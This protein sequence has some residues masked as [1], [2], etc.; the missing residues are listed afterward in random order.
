MINSGSYKLIGQFFRAVIGS[1]TRMAYDD[2]DWSVS[3]HW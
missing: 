2:R 3:I 1:K